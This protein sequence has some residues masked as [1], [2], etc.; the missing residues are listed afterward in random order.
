[1]TTDLRPHLV[2]DRHAGLDFTLDLPQ[3][4]RLE[5]P[6][7][8]RAAAGD[9]WVELAR[10]RPAVV[11]GDDA[12]VRIVVAG[13]AR[14]GVRSLEQAMLA[15]LRHSRPGRGDLRALRLGRHV[16]L[17]LHVRTGTR[18]A[19]LQVRLALAEDGGRLLRL[20]LAAP[21][22]HPVLER[23]RWEPLAAS[24]RLR[25]AM[26]ATLPVLQPD[27]LRSYAAA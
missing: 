4:Y 11:T 15:Q 16:G 13:V 22:G 12:R 21:A 20:M 27:I 7:Q 3:G 14:A 5:L 8:P 23:A 2:T 19:P 10:A 25:Q 6:A 24:L 26:G 1:M 9:A 17:A 18:A